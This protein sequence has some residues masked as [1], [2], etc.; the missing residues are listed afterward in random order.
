[1]GNTGVI[2]DR[3][4]IEVGVAERLPFDPPPV[5]VV[6]RQFAGLK[7]EAGIRRI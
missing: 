4:L 1:M 7:A 5:E 6:F 2:V 3:L